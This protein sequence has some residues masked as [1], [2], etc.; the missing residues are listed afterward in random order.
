M[1]ASERCPSLNS[2]GVRCVQLAG[3]PGPHRVQELGRVVVE[4]LD[5]P[6][7]VP[8]L[9]A[10]APTLEALLEELEAL[11]ARATAEGFHDIAARLTV[12][13]RHIRSHT[14]RYGTRRDASLPRPSSTSR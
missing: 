10:P 6:G 13:S 5:A 2:T 11:A 8:P 7:E 1:S 3:H 14:H 12:E 9:A 4:W